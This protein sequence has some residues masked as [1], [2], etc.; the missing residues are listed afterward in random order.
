M[1]VDQVGQVKGKYKGK[2]KGK[3]K[4]GGGWF[5]YGFGGGKYGGKNSKGKSQFNGK[6]KG[7]GQDRNTCRLCGQQGHWG[8]ECPNRQRAQ[9]VTNQNQTPNSVAESEI[10]SSAGGKKDSQWIFSGINNIHHS[11]TTGQA[12]AHVPCCN[13]NEHKFTNDV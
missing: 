1:E 8:N 2:Q 9:T 7:G 11:K 12:S 6:G 3:D 13:S 5:P 4:K 10:A